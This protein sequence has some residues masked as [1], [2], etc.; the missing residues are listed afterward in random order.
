M[1]NEQIITAYAYLTAAR[2]YKDRGK[3]ILDAPG[4]ESPQ[5]DTLQD[6]IEYIREDVGYIKE[7]IEPGL[8]EAAEAYATR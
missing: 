7:C 3:W 2:I 5:F 6:L 4:Y 8:W 1:N